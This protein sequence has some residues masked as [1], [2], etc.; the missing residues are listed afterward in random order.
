MAIASW[1]VVMR[2]PL[3]WLLGVVLAASGCFSSSHTVAAGELAVLRGGAVAR[4]AVLRTVKGERV[5]L[6]PNS[7]VKLHHGEQTSAWLRA[8][9]LRTSARG[10]GVRQQIDWSELTTAQVRELDEAGWAALKET[11]PD[12]A[13][14]RAES[15]HI[16]IADVRN[17]A[18]WLPRFAARSI[19]LHPPAAIPTAGTL[20]EW[21]FE[22]PRHGLLVPTRPAEWVRWDSA[23]RRATL[24]LPATLTLER[25]ASWDDL[26]SLEVINP[27]SGKLIGMIGFTAAGVAAV[28]AVAAVDLMV[29][30]LTR[31]RGSGVPLKIAGAVV[32][33]G[34]RYGWGDLRNH[35]RANSASDGPSLGLPKLTTDIPESQPLFA[36]LARR[37]AIVRMLVSADTATE[38]HRWTGIQSSVAVGLRFWDLFELSGGARYLYTP[39][40]LVEGNRCIDAAGAM[41]EA[42]SSEPLPLGQ[43]SSWLGFAR[44]DLNLDLDAR[45]RVALRLGSEFG[46]GGAVQ[47]QGRLNFGLRIRLT[48]TWFLGAFGFNPTYTRFGR[49]E[50]LAPASGWRFLSG[51]ETGF[52]L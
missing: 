13:M 36:P 8:A 3:L 11:A 42:R 35:A 37:R 10:L 29:A 31:G 32:F 27:S 47:F 4:A 30:A 17:F 49:D 52:A 15:D 24:D 1:T 14:I 6:D 26:R 41:C 20:G 23:H 39:L 18:E 34:L 46:A 50:L 44:L 16:R 22:T 51:L 5:R 38:V 2:N 19:A 33:A 25:A 21:T 40:V 12:E 48:Q 45:R 28:A 7:Y 9:D 43:R